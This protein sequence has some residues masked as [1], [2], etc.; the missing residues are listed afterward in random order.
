MAEMQID[1]PILGQEVARNPVHAISMRVVLVVSKFVADKEC[2][3]QCTGHGQREAEYVDE[4]A[5][6]ISDYG[7]EGDGEIVPDHKR[8]F[9]EAFGCDFKDRASW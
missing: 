4:C 8:N 9:G 3:K 2:N 6:F 7:A 1:R 5:E